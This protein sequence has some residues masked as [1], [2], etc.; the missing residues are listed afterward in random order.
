MEKLIRRHGAV[1]IIGAAL[2]YLFWLSRPQWD[3]EMRFW[4]AVGDASL[5][6][7]YL[8][9]AL[10][11][12]T[13]FLPKVGKFLSIRREL[14]IWF[15]IFAI[16]HTLLILDG[17]AR[18]DIGLFMG[19]QFIPQLGGTVRLESGFG[20]ANLLGLL[21]T[22]IAL[23]L[24]ATSSDWA[25]RALGGSAWKFLHYGAYI[26]FYLVVMHTAY[27]M[28]IHFTM[29]FHRAPPP[30][31][32][33]FQFPFVALTL[34]VIALHIGAFFKTVAQQRRKTHRRQVNT[35]NRS[36]TSQSKRSQAKSS[37]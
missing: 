28:F 24:M 14:G 34:M 13:R 11:P 1:G 32:N 6:Y 37:D 2:I 23:P 21:A 26:I 31:P 3:P 36:L 4:R 7:L 35:E 16:T 8:T 18:W 25:I 15:G 17:W 33:W 12:I 30:D 19:Y 22:L 27:F 29:S 10:G 20:M 5:I 9:L